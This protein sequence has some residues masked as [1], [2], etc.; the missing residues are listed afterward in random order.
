LGEPG[1]IILGQPSK[2]TITKKG[3]Q[4]TLDSTE[5]HIETTEN[6]K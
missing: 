5:I 6:Y 3:L 1:K 2:T 4:T